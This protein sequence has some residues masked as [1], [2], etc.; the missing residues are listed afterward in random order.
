MAQ[1]SAIQIGSRVAK[2][3][4]LYS[5]VKELAGRLGEIRREPGHGISFFW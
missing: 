5:I 3:V 1:A 2:G 4:D